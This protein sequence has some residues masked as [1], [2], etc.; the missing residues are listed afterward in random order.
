MI[1]RRG[2]TISN[3]FD[4]PLINSSQEQI[5]GF[6][7]KIKNSDIEKEIQEELIFVLHSAIKQIKQFKAYG[8]Q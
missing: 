7:K 4:I 6:I 3:A 1:K 5:M 2:E 8:W